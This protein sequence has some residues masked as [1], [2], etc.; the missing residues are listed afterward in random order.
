MQV[1]KAGRWKLI[2]VEPRNLPN[3][4][5]GFY[6]VTFYANGKAEAAEAEMMQ[7]CVDFEI[8]AHL[9]VVRGVRRP[10]VTYPGRNFRA[11]RLEQIPFTRAARVAG[12]ARTIVIARVGSEE[13]CGELEDLKEGLPHVPCLRH[14]AMIMRMSGTYGS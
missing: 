4:D 6:Y 2:R 7:A 12:P 10:D 11:L 1:K 13:R 9:A 14:A 5:Q 3:L 8:H